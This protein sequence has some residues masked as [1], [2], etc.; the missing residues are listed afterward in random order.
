MG[1]ESAVRA[2]EVPHTEG[3]LFLFLSR[4]QESASL[5]PY[6]VRTGPLVIT[7]QHV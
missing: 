2:I 1:L 7:G 6:H 4:L 3:F 5:S